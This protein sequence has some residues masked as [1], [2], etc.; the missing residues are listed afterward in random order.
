MFS[1]GKD[2]SREPGYRDRPTRHRLRRIQPLT[3]TC[4]GFC[5]KD[6]VCRRK[7]VVVAMTRQAQ[8]GRRRKG[9]ATVARAPA[10]TN[11]VVV[12]RVGTICDGR[13]SDFRC[14]LL[15]CMKGIPIDA[16]SA[17]EQTSRGVAWRLAGQA[18]RASVP[19]PPGIA[20]LHPSN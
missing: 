8:G 17:Q 1:G 12:P 9:N 4:A 16:P 6:C 15:F 11:F 18:A 20:I 14:L 7:Q 19:I 5:W 13:C 10:V 3:A 2:C